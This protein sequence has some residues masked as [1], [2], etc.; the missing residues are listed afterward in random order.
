MNES[1]DRKVATLALAAFDD[2]TTR[3]VNIK[4]YDVAFLFAAFAGIWITVT[5]GKVLLLPAAV[6]TP[7]LEEATLLYFERVARD[8]RHVVMLWLIAAGIGTGLYFLF[9][10]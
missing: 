4:W 6:R 2:A 9:I 7:E 5:R 10:H 3:P 8:V 1:F